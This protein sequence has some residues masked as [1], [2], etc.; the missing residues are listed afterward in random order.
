[1]AMYILF[2]AFKRPRVNFFENFE[3]FPKL[4][5]AVYP[6]NLVPFGFKLCQ[7]S[8]QT[9]PN[10]LFFDQKKFLFAEIFGPKNQF[11]AIL[12]WFWRS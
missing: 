11:F 5:T 6:S 10:I 1:M 8:F 7:N 2:S 12:A 3:F 4:R 9:I